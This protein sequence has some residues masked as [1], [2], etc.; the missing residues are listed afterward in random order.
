MR[1][2]GQGAQVVVGA[3]VEVLSGCGELCAV[4]PAGGVAV[5]GAGGVAA[6]AHAE[7]RRGVPGGVEAVDDGCEGH[8]GADG[9]DD[10]ADAGPRELG[11]L[12]GHLVEVGGVFHA[13]RDLGPYE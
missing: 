13:E 11:G 12:F 2:E 7:D 1:V 8:A 5:E 9:D 3:G 6:D 10:A 4:L